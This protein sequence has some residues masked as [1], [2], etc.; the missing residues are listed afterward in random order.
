M[1]QQTFSTNNND[2]AKFDA[3]SIKPDGKS[4]RTNPW[5]YPIP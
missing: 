1:M 2:A 3:D 5:P 4:C